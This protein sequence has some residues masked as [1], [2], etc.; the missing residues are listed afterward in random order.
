VQKVAGPTVRKRSS[1][2]AE[3]FK[4]GYKIYTVRTVYTTIYLKEQ[5]K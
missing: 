5:T 2:W 1:K 4:Q 3:D